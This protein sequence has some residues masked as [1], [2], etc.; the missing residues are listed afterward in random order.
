MTRPDLTLAPMLS[1]YAGARH[2]KAG[3][4]AIG[5]RERIARHHGVWRDVVVIE[6][7]SPAVD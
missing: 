2:A 3:F 4:R 1:G 6:R 5:T 7:R